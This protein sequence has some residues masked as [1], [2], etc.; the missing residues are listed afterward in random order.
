MMTV[1][2]RGAS[3]IASN[4]RKPPFLSFVFVFLS[5]LTNVISPFSP[6]KQERPAIP[7]HGVIVYLSAEE[8]RVDLIQ[9]HWAEMCALVASRNKLATFIRDSSSSGSGAGLSGG[10]YLLFFLLLIALS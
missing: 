4:V 2:D 3:S 5:T 8:T 6:Y 7:Q 10:K 9:P 1:R